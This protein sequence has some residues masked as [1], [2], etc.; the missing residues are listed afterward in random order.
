MHEA[1]RLRVRQGLDQGGIGRRED[2]RG[3]A[4]AEAERQDDGGSERGGAPDATRGEAEVGE[5]RVH[6]SCLNATIGSTLAARRA[7]T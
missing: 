6:H 3:R 7:G 4:Q 1:F 2:R 5:Q